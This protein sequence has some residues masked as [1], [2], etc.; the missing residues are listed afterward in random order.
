MDV[1]KTFITKPVFT[2]M[3]V[4]AVI[5]FGLNSYPKI[6]IDQFPDVD[7]PVVTGPTVHPGADPESME[8]DV[9]D[10]LEEE[11]TSL[12]GLET[13]RSTSLES[14]SQ[15]ILQFS[16]EKNVDLAAQDV[17]DRVQATLSK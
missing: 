16:L 3:L 14:V 17:R 11:L 1:I 9:S 10:V 6:G 8:R 7:L 2:A 4:L 12:A 15:V 5:V 13:I